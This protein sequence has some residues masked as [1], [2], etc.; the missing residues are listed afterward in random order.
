MLARPVRC[1]MENMNPS[2]WNVRPDRRTGK[3]NRL[4]PRFAL[5]IALAALAC[6]SSS[7]TPPRSPAAVPQPAASPG[8]TAADVDGALASEWQKRGVVASDVVDDEHFLRRVY[9]DVIGRIPTVVEMDRFESD[10]QPQR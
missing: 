4:G 2:E 1:K 8:M 10:Q 5:V 7:H 9:L 6:R 3:M